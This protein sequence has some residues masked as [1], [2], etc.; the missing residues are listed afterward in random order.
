VGVNCDFAVLC[1]TIFLPIRKLWLG[2]MASLNG[3]N[4]FVLSNAAGLVLDGRLPIP[5]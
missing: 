3:F 1:E 4:E 2:S 5:G